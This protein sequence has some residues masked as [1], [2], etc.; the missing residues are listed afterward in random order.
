MSYRFPNLSRLVANQG[1]D[2]DTGRTRQRRVW[3]SM[4]ERRGLVRHTM[5]KGRMVMDGHTV[6]QSLAASGIREDAP[7][8][9]WLLWLVLSMVFLSAADVGGT[10]VEQRES[11]SGILESI[12]LDSN[13]V[14]I[15]NSLGQP[16]ILKIGKPYLLEHVTVGDRVTVVV[17]EDHE[18]IKLI[19]T[20]IPEL[21]PPTNQ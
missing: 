1:S 15:R 10:E 16:I 20:P 12:N 19:E 4:P 13:T 2:Q 18:I 17:N 6:D 3:L 5:G 14:L 7:I 8:T 11:V 21:P 9:T